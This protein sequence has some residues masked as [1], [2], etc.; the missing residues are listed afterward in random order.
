[1][2]VFILVLIDTDP[3]A[4]FQLLLKLFLSNVLDIFWANVYIFD[5]E[6]LITAHQLFGVW[7]LVLS[8]L[9]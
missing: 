1:M 3:L 6:I 5:L 9:A 8:K 7:L 2:F 4:P